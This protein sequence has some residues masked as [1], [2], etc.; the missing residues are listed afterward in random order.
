MSEANEFDRILDALHRATFDDALWPAASALIDQACGSK[1]NCIAFGYDGATRTDSRIMIADLSYHGQRAEELLQEYLQDFY[2]LDERI[3]RLLQL[4]DSKFVDTPNLYTEK[5][6]KSSVAYNDVLS[7][8]EFQKSLSVRLDGP[9]GTCII[10]NL[11]DPINGEAWSSMQ[12]EVARRLLPHLR[13]YMTTRQALL[14]AGALGATLGAALEMTGCGILQLDW[15]GRIVSTNDC[16]MQVLK[17]NG[18]LI[19]E[20]GMLRARSSRDNSVLQEMLAKA[21]PGFGKLGVGSSTQLMRRNGHPDLWVH[22]SPVSRKDLALRPLRVAALVLVVEQ[23]VEV[24]IDPDVVGESLGLTPTESQ[25][26]T[27]LAQGDTISE[28]A[29]QWDRSERTIRWHV[30]QIYEKLDISRQT[31]LVRR[32]L[33]LADRYALR[34]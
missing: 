12:V 25:L 14:D 9:K 33:L 29:A 7:R 1:G 6:R 11:A 22:I 2:Y 16:A 31:E 17:G 26:A 10:W 21:L 4:P 5:E 23:G 18:A 20:Q 32:V 13:Q 19:D 27:R 28:I 8:G 3:P 34:H 24:S 15:R 30:M